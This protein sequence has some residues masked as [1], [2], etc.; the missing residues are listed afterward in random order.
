[1]KGT[2]CCSAVTAIWIGASAAF[3]QDAPVAV[4]RSGFYPLDLGTEWTYELEGK[5][6]TARVTKHE[7]MGDLATGKVDTFVADELV[8]TEHIAVL[9]DGVY[10]VAFGGEVAA[11]P[12]MILKLPPKDGEVWSVETSIA[13]SRIKGAA[14]CDRENVKTP[15]G[16]FDA[17][18]VKGSYTVT[19]PDGTEANPEFTFWFADGTGVVK[20][21]TKAGDGNVVLELKSYRKGR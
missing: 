15:A 20:L 11:K 7:K 5:T 6:V 17:Y 4:G 21:G 13:G 18:R 10:R 1:M 12:V 14:R 2:L 3:G 19:A 9:A 8:S 16:E